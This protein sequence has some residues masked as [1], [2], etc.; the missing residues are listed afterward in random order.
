MSAQSRNGFTIIETVLFVSISGALMVLLATGWTTMLN[1]QRYRDSVNTL[2]SFI[3]QQYDLVYNVQNG[4]VGKD[5]KC[6]SS[7]VNGPR[8]TAQ[9]GA[10]SYRGT[11]SCVFLGRYVWIENGQNLRSYLVLGS[12]PNTELASSLTEAQAIAAY[13]P[14]LVTDVEGIN[15]SE[16]ELFVPWSAVVF[17]EASGQAKTPRNVGIAILRSPRTGIAHTYIRD[18]TTPPSAV[19]LKT[20]FLDLPLITDEPEE[21]LCIDAG[22]PLAGGDMAIIFRENAAAQSAIESKSEAACDV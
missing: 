5:L 6:D 19:N 3:Q 10:G 4:R 9:E 1:T 7:G 17:N 21:L 15:A 14:Q 20:S 16:S 22:V 11:E 18:I 8:V 13:K 12:E 2:Q